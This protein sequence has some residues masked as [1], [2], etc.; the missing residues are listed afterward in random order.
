MLK[1]HQMFSVHTTPEELKNANNRSF[2]AYICGYTYMT[3]TPEI[4]QMTHHV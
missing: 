2:C 1:T 4:V 3:E